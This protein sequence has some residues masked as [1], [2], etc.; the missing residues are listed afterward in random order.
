L[1]FGI[2]TSL[3]KDSATE[4]TQSWIDCIQSLKTFLQNKNYNLLNF[5]GHGFSKSLVVMLS[6]FDS[7]HFSKLLEYRKKAASSLYYTTAKRKN[8]NMLIDKK[9][10]E[11]NQKFSINVKFA[12]IAEEY[13]NDTSI[14]DLAQKYD[15]HSDTV[16]RNLKKQGIIISRKKMKDEEE[17][18]AIHLY[19]SGLMVSDIAE[20]LNVSKSTIK[21]CLHR[22]GV[23][24]RMRRDYAQVA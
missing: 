1:L 15:C 17:K 13:H 11:Q 4:P 16:I 22:N 7:N 8:P 9:K 21:R 12:S 6:S 14:R 5:F 24:M 23:K 18:E 3:G 2:K 10:I 20:R 19:R